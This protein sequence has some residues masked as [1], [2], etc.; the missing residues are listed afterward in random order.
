[1]QAI[2]KA[3]RGAGTIKVSFDCQKWSVIRE[4]L[5]AKG[6]L[7]VIDPT[8]RIGTDG[9]KGQA[10]KWSLSAEFAA[11]VQDLLSPAACVKAGGIFIRTG[12][13]RP[14]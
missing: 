14:I 5:S 2:W 13:R 11:V 8:Y 12:S 3:L 6:L 9:Q 4:T 1:M 10:M 7:N